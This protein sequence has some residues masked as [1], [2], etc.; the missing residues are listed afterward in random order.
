MRSDEISR[1]SYLISISSVVYALSTSPSLDDALIIFTK[2]FR[3]TKRLA[4]LVGFEF[5]SVKISSA[6]SCFFGTN[7]S[8]LLWPKKTETSNNPIY[9]FVRE[10]TNS[11]DN[12]KNATQYSLF[13]M[14]PKRRK[15]FTIYYYL[16]LCLSL[17]Y[18]CVWLFC[19]D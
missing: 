19:T 13:C 4:A 6:V 18:V 7:A 11:N 15:I 8:F 9:Y 2:P 5:N 12:N 17:V 1:H 14:L 16:S 10:Q 3:S